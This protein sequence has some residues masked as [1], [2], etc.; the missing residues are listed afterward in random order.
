MYECVN[1]LSQ[2]WVSWPRDADHSAGH[3]SWPRDHSALR[4]FLHVANSKSSKIAYPHAKADAA[5]LHLD[6]K[7]R[8]L[9]QF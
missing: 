9:R 3:L 5:W 7:C 8:D 4:L 6:A 1:T 2:N